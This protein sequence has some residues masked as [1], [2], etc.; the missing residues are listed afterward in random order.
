METVLDRM[1]IVLTATGWSKRHWA[2]RAGLAESGHVGGLMRRMKLNP[3]R[4]AGDITTYA[5]LAAAAGVSL[6]WLVLGR[7][8]PNGIAAAVEEDSKYPS[9]ARVV[10]AARLLGRY[11]DEVISAILAHNDPSSDPG[12]EF[13]VALLDLKRAE[14]PAPNPSSRPISK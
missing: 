13:W 6:D 4:L 5:K 9:R 10:V 3:D 14:A 7:G 11:S 2:E 12:I 8:T 1:E